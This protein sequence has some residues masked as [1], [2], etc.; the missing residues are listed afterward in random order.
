MRQSRRSVTT[1]GA[2]LTIPGQSLKPADLLKRALAGTLP[3]LD[4]SS[5]FEFH[6]DENGEEIAQPMPMEMHELHALAVVIR[7]RQFEEA[8]ERRKQEAQKFKE[9]VIDEYVKQ[10]LEKQQQQKQDDKPSD[11]PVNG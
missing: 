10:Q 11:K 7:K 5:K 2:S 9:Q 8:T 3:P 6:Y 1:Y 4:Q